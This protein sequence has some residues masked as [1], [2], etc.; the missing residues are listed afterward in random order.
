MNRE[1]EGRRGRIYG[2]IALGLM[3]AILVALGYFVAHLPFWACVLIA[4][5]AMVVNSFVLS[6]EDSKSFDKGDSDR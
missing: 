5:G 4:I 6:V 2:L 3:F 1:T